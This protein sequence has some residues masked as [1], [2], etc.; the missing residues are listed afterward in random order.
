MDQALTTLRLTW[1]WRGR[2]LRPLA[3]P[4]LALAALA[5]V[6]W[7]TSLID[8]LQYA[9]GL[10]LFHDPNSLAARVLVRGV[11]L[12]LYAT[13]PAL[14]SAAILSAITEQAAPR[15]LPGLGALPLVGALVAVELRTSRSA[16]RHAT[17]CC[18]TSSPSASTGSRAIGP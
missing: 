7:H 17:S 8:D 4:L 5:L 10:R 16:Y 18:G 6:D 9:V 15:W 14:A 11:V 1:R 3:L 12:V 2:F 13:G